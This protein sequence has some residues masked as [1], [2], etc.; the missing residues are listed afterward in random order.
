MALVKKTATPSWIT[1]FI[2]EEEHVRCGGAVVA[3]GKDPVTGLT[4][5]IV[6]TAAHCLSGSTPTHA[7]FG[8][9][10]LKGVK[11]RDRTRMGIAEFKGKEIRIAESVSCAQYSDL[12]LV[13]ILLLPWYTG[14]VPSVAPEIGDGS[15]SVSAYYWGNVTTA[16]DQLHY[17]GGLQRSSDDDCR[18][19]I[20]WLENQCAGSIKVLGWCFE[21][22]GSICEAGSS[23]GPVIVD[24]AIA[25]FLCGFGPE[26][27]THMRFAVGARWKP[28]EARLEPQIRTVFEAARYCGFSPWRDNPRVAEIGVWG[29]ALFSI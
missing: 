14:G 16:L 9:H 5:I 18:A 3:V 29:P 6:A 11:P 27:A 17:K 10:T 26:G 7:I 22:V 1:G 23:G 13:K 12:A 21:C 25:G 20:T 2:V 19:T 4:A 24:G 28:I 15:G 8:R